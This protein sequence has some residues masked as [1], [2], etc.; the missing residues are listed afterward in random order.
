[1]TKIVK[2]EMSGYVPHELA[3][4]FLQHVR[5][6]DAMNPG[7]HFQI[8]AVSDH[9]GKEIK[10]IFESLDPPLPDIRSFRKQ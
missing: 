3:Q 4:D 10:S 9:T 6:F 1:M 8:T 5:D 2:I 7:C